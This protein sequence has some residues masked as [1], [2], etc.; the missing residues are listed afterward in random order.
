MSI[1]F[2]SEESELQKL[3][4]RLCKMPDEELVRFGKAAPFNLHVSR[5]FLF[6]FWI[7]SF[8]ARILGSQ[9]GSLGS[10]VHKRR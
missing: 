7:P 10:G 2:E 4:E 3:R 5:H 6:T 1:S 8:S 9:V